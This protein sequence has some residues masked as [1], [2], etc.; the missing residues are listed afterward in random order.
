MICD[1]DSGRLKRGLCLR[2]YNRF[3]SKKRRLSPEDAQAFDDK[4]VED[5]YILPSGGKGGRPKQDDD[6]FDEVLAEI[7]GEG[8]AEITAA[9][10]Q[11][12]AKKSKAP[13]KKSTKKRDAQ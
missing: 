2:H 5:G 8:H 7:I 12:E 11:Q 6:P 1:D 13:T 4:C 3:T 10:K 9:E